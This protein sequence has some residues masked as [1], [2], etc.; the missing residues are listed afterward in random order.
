MQGVGSATASAPTARRLS[1]V[2]WPA[3]A[4]TALPFVVVGAIW[5]IT[6]HLQVFPAHINGCIRNAV[7]PPV[8]QLPEKIADRQRVLQHS[9]IEQAPAPDPDQHDGDDNSGGQTAQTP[10]EPRPFSPEDAVYKKAVDMLKTPA[11]KAA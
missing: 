10:V 9:R 7:D 3:I 8:F 11:K 4:A 6:A 5:E 1:A 2:R